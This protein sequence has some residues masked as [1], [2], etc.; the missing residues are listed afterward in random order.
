MTVRVQEEPFDSGQ[1]L[2]RFSAGDGGFGA[3]V[4]F[5]GIVRTELRDPVEKLV[6]EHYPAMTERAIQSMVS[7]AVGRWQIG[8]C[9]IIHRFGELMPGDAIMMVAV[10]AAHRSDAFEASRFLMD[11]LKSRAPFWKKEFRGGAAEWVS[12]L[13][14]DEAALQSWNSD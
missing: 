6:I 12:S 4:S 10:R 9:L 8:D 1:E 14:E 11:Y 13:T 7:E 3:V 2:N 5:T